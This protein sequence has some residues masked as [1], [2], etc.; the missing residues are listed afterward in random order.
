MIRVDATET[1][2]YG[3]EPHERTT[4]SVSVATDAGYNPDA[5]SDLAARLV[6]IWMDMTTPDEDEDEP[7]SYEL[8]MDQ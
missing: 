7:G 3:P 4:L 2:Q 8:E 6:D 1:V 5:A